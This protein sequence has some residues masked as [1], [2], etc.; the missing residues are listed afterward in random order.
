MLELGVGELKS[1]ALAIETG[2]ETDLRCT[3]ELKEGSGGRAEGADEG[4][5]LD[6]IDLP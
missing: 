2:V 1:R 5:G 3:A 4:E 6:D